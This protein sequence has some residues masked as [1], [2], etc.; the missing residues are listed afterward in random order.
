MQ[1]ALD[2]IELDFLKEMLMALKFPTQFIKWVMSCVTLVKFIIH[3][4]GQD[5][6]VCEG[7]K[8]LRQEDPLLPLLFVICMEKLSRLM[9]VVSHKT[10][11]RFHPNCKYLGL[12]HLLF[13]NDLIMFCK[14][15]PAA[16]K[17]I[18]AV[19]Y[20]FHECVGLESNIQKSQMMLGGVHKNFRESASRLQDWKITIS[21]LNTWVYPSQQ[22]D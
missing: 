7:G 12:T 18:I 22:V 6:G 20:D 2:S 13:A 21:L 3:N 17:H 1:K 11:L 9:K 5:C 15:D 10:D 19:L 8:G 16:L 14:A 4:N